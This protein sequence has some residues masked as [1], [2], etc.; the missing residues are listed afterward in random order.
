MALSDAPVP[1]GIL[2]RLPIIGT[3]ARDIARE[4][5]SVFYLIAGLLSL[6][7]I[8]TVQW[9]LAVLAMAALAMVPVVF[10]LLIAITRG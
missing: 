4:P 2:Y 10:G 9:G 3:I 1:G 7:I 6:L 8:G 5:E